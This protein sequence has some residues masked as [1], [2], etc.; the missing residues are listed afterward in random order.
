MH[1]HAPGFVIG[2]DVG[3][4]R[5][6]GVDLAR[7]ES[8]PLWQLLARGR[9]GRRRFN[10]FQILMHAGMVN[11]LASS[12]AQRALADAILRPPLPHIDLLSWRSFDRAVE[13]GYC[14]ARK[15]LEE[16]PEVPRLSPAMP[17]TDHR[18]PSSLA[19]ELDRRLS[20]RAAR[21]G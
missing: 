2:C 19:A 6:F 13:A 16:L 7:S 20:V 14:H 9:G 17:A 18:A 21:A 15:V 5:S 12:L 11:S 3:A 8:P 10:I 1:L 4:D